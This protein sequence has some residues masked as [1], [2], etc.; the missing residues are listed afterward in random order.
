M[1]TSPVVWSVVAGEHVDI[2]HGEDED[3]KTKHLQSGLAQDIC[4]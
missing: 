3:N 4:T 1:P 2:S